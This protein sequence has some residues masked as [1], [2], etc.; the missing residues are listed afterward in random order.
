[1]PRYIVIYHDR[2]DDVPQAMWAVVEAEDS[3]AAEEF[4]VAQFEEHNAETSSAREV[5]SAFS[6]E[7][8]DELV[9]ALADPERKPDY[10]A[11]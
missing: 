10:T 7:D 2:N 1:M 4:L 8:V 11:P 9:R 5:L 3:L 6:P